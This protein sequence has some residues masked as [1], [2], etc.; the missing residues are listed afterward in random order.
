V[1]TIHGFCFRTLQQHAFESG[2]DFAAELQ[3]DGGSLLGDLVRGVWARATHAADPMVVRHLL[4]TGHDPASLLDL[5]RRVAR[6]PDVAVVPPVEAA[7]SPPGG[8]PPLPLVDA[9]RWGAWCDAVA[10]VAAALSRGAPRYRGLLADLALAKSTSDP[11]FTY[12]DVVDWMEQLREFCAGA[13]RPGLALP[14]AAPALVAA[15]PVGTPAGDHSVTVALRSLVAVTQTLAPDLDA[16]SLAL[17]HEVVRVVRERLPVLRRQRGVL[18]FDDLLRELHLGLT[19]PVRGPALADAIRT[20]YKAALIDEFQDTDPTQYAIFR[21]LFH[22]QPG[23]WL[24]MIGDPKQAIYAFRG[25]DVFTYLAARADATERSTLAENRRSDASM[26]AAVNH[27]FGRVPRPFLIEA[28]DYPAVSA[29]NPDRI[30]RPP[31]HGAAALRITL[32]PRD[33]ANVRRDGLLRR[34]WLTRELPGLVARDIAAFLAEGATIGGAPVGPA[35]VAVLTRSNAQAWSVQDA[36]RELGVP[37]VLHSAASVFETREAEELER[38][39]RAMREPGRASV[40]RA[41]LVTAPLGLSARD[42]IALDRDDAAWDSWIARFRAWG[43]LWRERGIVRAV[44]ALLHETD[45]A[46]RVLAL[47]DGERRMTNLLHLA[48]LLHASARERDLGPTRVCRLLARERRRP[49]MLGDARQLRLE[50]DD[51]AVRLVTMH[52]SKGLE[53]PVVWCPFLWDGQELRTLDEQHVEVHR[54]DGARVLDIGSAE[55]AHHVELL[56]RERL[57]EELRLAYVALTRA[58][59]RCVVYLAMAKGVERSALGLLFSPEPDVAA[60]QAIRMLTEPDS[61]ILAGLDALAA[62]SG[63]AVEVASIPD[64]APRFVVP[65]DPRGAVAPVVPAPERARWDDGWRR[66]SFSAIVA[67]RHDERPLGAFSDPDSER[68]PLAGPPVPLAAFPG[69]T[70]SGL[71]FHGLLEELPLDAP[72]PAWAERARAHLEAAR[73]D[74]AWAE[75]VAACL[76]AVVSTPLGA[77]GPRLRE[78]PAR[79]RAAELAFQVPVDAPGGLSVAAIAELI[80]RH[81]FDGAP[82]GYPAVLAELAAVAGRD[83]RGRDGWAEALREVRVE[84]ADSGHGLLVGSIDLLFRADGRWW[85]VDWKS[86]NLGP[87]PEHYGVDG[88][89]GAMT[90]HHYPLQA[91]IYTL[92]VHRWLGARLPAYDYERDVGGARYVFLR[93]VDAPGGG[94]WCGRPTA[95]LVYALDARLR[96]VV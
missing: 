61:V 31:P 47:P 26:V 73:L 76:T 65:A 45:A 39:L 91:L 42:L 18:G 94:V 43:R 62:T 44:R 56:R 7:G 24:Y 27:V 12:G 70:A 59:H 1:S 28:I 2:A 23:R 30:V 25:A 5:A 29:F 37:S 40:V 69:G 11:P 85:I 79:D 10:G 14:A 32:V 9:A 34:D 88:L 36:L 52:S 93:G 41:A 20:R 15:L 21:T 87:A 58:R 49:E 33:R 22:G 57:A 48:E 16:A 90:D 66:T 3:E 74:P 67:G 17:E 75:P 55:R 78:V 19:H 51:A 64:V 54:S 92:A 89:N 50:S 4:S 72:E 96:G 83:A 80:E 86:N 60:D 63:G 46:R 35:D 84:R 6:E 82:P 77:D 68:P 53:Y 71:F 38:I 95:Q 13:P 8:A 81:G